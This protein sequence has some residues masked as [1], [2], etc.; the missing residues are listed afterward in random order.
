MPNRL[1]NETSPYLLQHANNP[2]DW[3]AWGDEALQR[4]AAEDKPI[5]LSIGYSA[6]HWCHVMEHESFEDAEI[7]ESLNSQFICIKVDREE[8]PDLDN[9]YMVAVQM[10]TGRGGWPMSVFLTPELKPFFGGTYWPPRAR[11]GMPGFDQVIVAV[12]DAWQ[13]RRDQADDQASQLSERI[14]SLSHLA[15]DGITF[16]NPTLLREAAG[17]LEQSFDFSHGGFGGAPKFPSPLV[18][19]FLLRVWHRFGRDGPLEMIRLTLDKMA[20]GGIYDHLAGGFARYSVDERWLVPHFE[21]MLYD[22]AQLSS[23]YLDAFTATGDANYAR[24]ARETLDYILNYMTD[25]R[26]GFHSTEDADSEGEEGKF[27]VWTP[28]EVHELLGAETAERFCYVYDVSEDGNFEGKNILNLPK[29]LEQC[30]QIKGWDLESLQVE[31]AAARTRLLEVRDRRVRPGKDDKI[32]VSWNALM[33][34]SMARAAGILDESKYLDAARA[35]ADFILEEMRCENGELLHVWRAGTAKVDA[36]LDDYAALANALLTLYESSFEE[37]WIDA[38]M[39]LAE[40]MIKRFADT[41]NPGFFYTAEDQQS[42]IARTK[43]V[44]DSAVPSGNA[45]AATVL[46]RLGK[47]CGRTDFLDRAREVLDAAVGVIENT[48]SAAG[49]MM[50]A[51]DMLI[52]PF[53]ELVVLGPQEDT[54]T[55][56]TLADFRRR[57]IPNRVIAYRPMAAVPDG[58]RH[59]D[60]IFTGRT[61]QQP[62]PTVYV[63]ERFACQAPCN[64]LD[65]AKGAWD[66][67]SASGGGTN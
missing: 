49:Q 19:Q 41:D 55:T 33:I 59:V 1:T 39:Q 66:A 25:S 18:L 4:S 37:C 5:F 36:F 51:M 6:C 63:C 46:V 8:R 15:S 12:A 58:S 14:Q 56:S 35:A 32:L 67:L 65:A 26:G 24:V 22:N 54:A 13:N 34:D 60:P 61:E 16:A 52:G 10:L 40:T 28:A 20:A 27:Y 21:K 47:L 38:A 62:A 29:T 30:A 50:I 42:L 31:L 45:L 3:Y 43:D 48:P 11:M 44:H 9:I 64:G 7:A 57:Y 53:L 23:V 17:R 2:V